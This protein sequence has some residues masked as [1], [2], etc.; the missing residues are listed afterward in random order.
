MDEYSAL[1]LLSQEQQRSELIPLGLLEYSHAALLYW[2]P[3]HSGDEDRRSVQP[4]H[5]LLFGF[6]FCASSGPVVIAYS[7]AALVPVVDSWT[8]WHST[9]GCQ[10][11]ALC[12]ASCHRRG[13][14]TAIVPTGT[15][16]TGSTGEE[17]SYRLGHWEV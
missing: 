11:P 17:Y 14:G 9:A 16:S 5:L 3:S 10:V 6:F 13:R 7:C 2:L 4:A 8:G 12:N 1:Y 15:L